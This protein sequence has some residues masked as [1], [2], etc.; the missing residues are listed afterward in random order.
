MLTIIKLKPKANMGKVLYFPRCLEGQKL[1]EP[2]RKTFDA[3]EIEG[4]L[5]KG[6]RV[7]LDLT[8]GLGSKPFVVEIK[9]LTQE[10]I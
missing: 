4:L 8:H 1:L 3:D 6:Q 5:S 7:A 9:T 10:N 2:G